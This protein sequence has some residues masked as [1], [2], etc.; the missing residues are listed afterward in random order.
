MIIEYFNP[1][2]DLYNLY[3]NLFLFKANFNYTFVFDQ[4]TDSLY[5]N[6]FICFIIHNDLPKKRNFF[7]VFLVNLMSKIP[8]LFSLALLN[9]RISL[10]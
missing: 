2:S 9:S 8:S 10:A 7:I 5:F 6:H 1:L 3:Q 4:F